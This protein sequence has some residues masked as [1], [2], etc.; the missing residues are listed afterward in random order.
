MKIDWTRKLTSRKF[1]MAL[2]GLIGGLVV[3][4]GGS[5]ATETQI[6]ALI[7]SAGSVIAFVF[8]ESLIDAADAGSPHQPEAEKPPET[9]EE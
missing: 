8:G 9:N 2:A 1:W 7:L 4:F 6:T 3:A 5:Q